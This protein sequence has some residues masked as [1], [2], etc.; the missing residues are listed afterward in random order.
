MV[1]TNAIA[2]FLTIMAGLLF[3][4]L[5]ASAS[6]VGFSISQALEIK[7][8]DFYHFKTVP[9]DPA[10]NV[11]EQ[12]A[13]EQALSLAKFEGNHEAKY[14]WFLEKNLAFQ[15]TGGPGTGCQVGLYFDN[16]LERIKKGLE[17]DWNYSATD[18][19]EDKWA[20]AG[21]ITPWCSATFLPK[22]NAEYKHSDLGFIST[23]PLQENDP[24]AFVMM[25]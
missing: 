9:P 5:S 19:V 7:S 25:T 4:T 21:G 23:R 3:L 22:D 6:P 18:K 1:A 8:S 15:N 13:N 11:T 17:L 10:N 14:F 16:M 2:K 24:S 20:V 12:M